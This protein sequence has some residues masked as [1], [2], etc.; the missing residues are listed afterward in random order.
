MVVARARQAPSGS[1]AWHGHDVGAEVVARTA[2]PRAVVAPWQQ[3]LEHVVGADASGRRRHLAS[4]PGGAVARCQAR[5]ASVGGSRRAPRQRLGA[6][7][8]RT[9]AVVVAQRSPSRRTGLR[10]GRAGRRRRRRWRRRRAGG[11][12][13]VGR[14]RRGR[15]GS[16]R[17]VGATR[18][19]HRLGPSDRRGRRAVDDAVGRRAE[20]G[21]KGGGAEVLRTGSSA[22]P[23]AAPWRARR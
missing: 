13:V 3:M 18:R 15:N 9:G 23:W 22:A 4:G 5:R 20:A 7:R 17:G 10:R 11:E 8:T 2:A 16:A 6:A 19:A 1:N 21:A 12:P 14:G